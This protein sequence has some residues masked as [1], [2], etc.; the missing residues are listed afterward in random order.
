MEVELPLNLPPARTVEISRS[1]Y[2]R[3]SFLRSV[4]RSKQQF[5]FATALI[6][7]VVVAKVEGR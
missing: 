3:T 6:L 5:V 7:I 4:P 1:S 2:T